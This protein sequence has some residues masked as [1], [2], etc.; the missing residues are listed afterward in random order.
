MRCHYATLLFAPLVLAVT[1]CTVI[2]GGSYDP[3]GDRSDEHRRADLPYEIG[4]L[5]TELAANAES[6][7]S[8][9]NARIQ[10]GDF[11]AIQPRRS[12]YRQVSLLERDL[13]ATEAT[14]RHELAMALGNRVNVV[15]AGAVSPTHIIEGEFLRTAE[16]LELS[17]RLVEL[18]SDWIV[19]TARR[20]IDDFVPEYY[21]RR[22]Q[23]SPRVEPTEASTTVEDAGGEPLGRSRA[24]RPVYPS[25]ANTASLP[26]ASEILT[27]EP[28]D[29]LDQG[30]PPIS[31]LPPAGEPVIFESGPAASRLR[32]GGYQGSQTTPE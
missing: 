1:G 5:A 9:G 30:A 14:V 7:A 6:R 32:T 8:L 25:G 20:H 15:G 10:L 13:R 3:R 22:L 31:A 29:G 11:D 24:L 12:P 16:S 4:E 26:E 23:P 17:L 28:A 19:A 27:V 18:K 21:D 2:G